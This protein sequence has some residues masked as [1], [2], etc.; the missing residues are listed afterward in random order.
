V[1][2][3]LG[4]PDLELRLV[5][6]PAY[7]PDYNADEAIWKWAR[8]EVTANTCWGT[9]SRVHTELAI[10]FDRLAA[11]PNDVRRRCRT[12]LQADLVTLL[13]EQHGYPTCA[14]V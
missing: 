5:A 4:T 3:Y 6:L 11:R 1:R 9:A 7:S 10:F 12:Q 13:D 8:V 14:S 2:R